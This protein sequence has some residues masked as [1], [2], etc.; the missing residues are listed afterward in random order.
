VH[1]LHISTRVT[2]E[3]MVVITKRKLKESAAFAELDARRHTRALKRLKRPIHCHMINACRTES[4]N[5][6]NYA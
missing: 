4:F 5:D 2:D 3:V 1:V 6:T